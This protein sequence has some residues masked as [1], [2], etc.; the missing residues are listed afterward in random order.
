MFLLLRPSPGN[1]VH[2]CRNAEFALYRSRW[3][4]N[5]V[6]NDKAYSSSALS[7]PAYNEGH[8][9]KNDEHSSRRTNMPN[10]ASLLKDEIVRL[11]RREL[12]RELEGLRKASAQYRSDI[13][14]LKRRVTDLEKLVSRA[15]KKAPGTATAQTSDESSTKIRFRAK[16]L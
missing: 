5:R 16:G 8:V 10:I 2:V 4:C 9:S 1:I 7:H 6:L 12:R 11:A 13:A 14:G 15:A 3:S